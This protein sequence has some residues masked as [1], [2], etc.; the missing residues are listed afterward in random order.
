[1]ARSQGVTI[2]RQSA[3]GHE[4]PP[5]NIE[6]EESTLGPMLLGAESV[7]SVV[8][9]GLVASDFYQ[10]AHGLIFEAIMSLYARGERAE[11]ITVA[12]ELRRAGL[13]DQVG[14]SAKLVTLQANSPVIGNAAPYAVIVQ[15]RAVLRRMITAGARL[16]EI[17]YSV[18]AELSDALCE[19]EGLFLGLLDRRD[20]NATRDMRQMIDEELDRIEA[21]IQ[22]GDAFT[23]L[24]T[25]FIE[26]D[27]LMGGLQ[28]GTLTVIG[29]RPGTGKSAMALG[30]ALHVAGVEKVPVQMFS[31]EMSHQEIGQRALSA[32]AKV[33]AT[34]IRDGRLREP[35]WPRLSLA[36]SRL[37]EMPFVVEDNPD[38]TMMEIR[39]KARSR[40]GR[41]G[42]GLVVV[43]Y[44]QQI[45]AGSARE[46]RQLQVAEVSRGLKLMA[47]EMDIPV[48]AVAMVSRGPDMR[49][50]KRPTLADLRESGGIEG[51]ADAVLLI[52]RDELYNPN[53]SDKG[54]AEVILAKHRHGPTGV[55][56]LAFIERFTQFANLA[57]RSE[58]V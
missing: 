50:E 5:H 14:G 45:G 22:R 26:L 32:E 42:L 35:D 4:P 51:D 38:A 40:K 13:L 47:R 36:T 27:G 18:P 31:L 28:P 29:G 55:V 56:Y 41:S 24:R 19:A 23:G 37:S 54:M 17:G 48:L 44:L 49:A 58:H 8:E 57:R 1:M 20:N 43:D 11:P 15:E 21:V 46:N 3:N 9:V 12:E 10:P 39:T 2:P 7:G 52:F 6:A 30:V 16:A 34:R 33:D 53:S 25:G